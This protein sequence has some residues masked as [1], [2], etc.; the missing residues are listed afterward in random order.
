MHWTWYINGLL[1]KKSHKMFKTVIH[2]Q[3]SQTYMSVLASELHRMRLILWIHHK[4]AQNVF[5]F[6]RWGPLQWQFPSRYLHRSLLCSAHRKR[7]LCLSIFVL[8]FCLV[9]VFVPL[10]DAYIVSKKKTQ[11][12]REILNDKSMRHREVYRKCYLRGER[13]PIRLLCFRKK[14]T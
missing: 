10:Y 12:I 6:W 7:C 2:L 14:N 5:V 8:Y 13:Q 3:Y 9:P 1:R 11:I 4:N